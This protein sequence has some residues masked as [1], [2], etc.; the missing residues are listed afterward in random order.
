MPAL[1]PEVLALLAC[2]VCWQTLELEQSPAAVTVRCRGCERRY[3]IVDGIPV[4]IP[5]RSIT[6]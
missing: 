5:E 4:L 1:S 2:P 3:P 6:R